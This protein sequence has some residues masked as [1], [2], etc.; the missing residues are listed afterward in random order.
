MACKKSSSSQNTHGLCIVSAFSLCVH[1]GA[2]FSSNANA[3]LPRTIKM[4]SKSYRRRFSVTS[5][6]F[7][8]LLLL[9]LGI[10]CNLKFNES[11][12]GHNFTN[13]MCRLLCVKSLSSVEHNSWSLLIFP[14]SFFV[15]TAICDRSVA[16][17]WCNQN[18][19]FSQNNSPEFKLL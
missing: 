15:H 10:M 17:V 13:R 7:I 5:L 14:R 1:I 19:V 18:R 8:V 6:R 16:F 9:L 12:N 11:K 3:R 2:L 4:F